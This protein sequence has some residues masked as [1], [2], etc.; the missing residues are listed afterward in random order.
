[1]SGLDVGV[2]FATV[3]AESQVWL[4]LEERRMGFC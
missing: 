3:V 4:M 1:M 2:A